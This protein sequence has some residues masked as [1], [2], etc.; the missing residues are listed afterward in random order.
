MTTV[1]FA[2]QKPAFRLGPITTKSHLVSFG[3][4]TR[5]SKVGAEMHFFWFQRPLRA[6]GQPECACGPT[7]RRLAAKSRE[8]RDDG[9]G[10]CDAQGW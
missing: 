10:R 1:L 6:T 4:V 9:G 3:F 5:H 8:R 7:P 2:N